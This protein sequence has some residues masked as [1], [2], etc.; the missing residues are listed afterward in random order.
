MK[1]LN[2]YGKEFIEKVKEEGKLVDINEYCQVD[3]ITV[4]QSQTS[5][6]INMDAVVHIEEI[7]IYANEKYKLDIYS[8]IECNEIFKILFSST[9]EN[10]KE[11]IK[12][13]IEDMFY[14]I[15]D[16]DIKEITESEYYNSGDLSKEEIKNKLE[17]A[18]ISR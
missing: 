6:L 10:K 2:A 11:L 9:S 3:N 17:A 5:H 15:Y 14:A 4:T 7:Y 12:N 8:E 18:I 13:F 16:Y 1:R